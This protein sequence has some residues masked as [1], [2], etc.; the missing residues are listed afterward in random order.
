MT[1]FEA[2][3]KVAENTGSAMLA[4]QAYAA[5]HFTGDKNFT[6]EQYN[7][8]PANVQTLHDLLGRD[9][10]PGELAAYQHGVANVAAENPT[11]TNTTTHYKNGEAVGQTNVTTGGY[12]ERQAEIDAAS[13][14]SPEVAQNQ[15]ATTYYNALVD[16]LRAAV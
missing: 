11:V 7:G 8:Q 1:P 10:T 15:Q 4:K 12:D 6:Q 5:A 2:A 9:P 14:A 3:Q 16:A 13:S